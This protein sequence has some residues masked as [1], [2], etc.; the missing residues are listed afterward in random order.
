MVVDTIIMLGLGQF[1]HVAERAWDL[2]TGRAWERL[3]RRV[4]GS[5]KLDEP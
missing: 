3:L 1:F 2:L 4:L 5:D